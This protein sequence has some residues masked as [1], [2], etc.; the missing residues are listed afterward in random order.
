MKILIYPQDEKEL[1]KESKNIN[2]E[3]LST[4]EFK[5]NITEMTELAKQDGVGLAAAQ[6]GWNINLFLIMVDRN[7]NKI[8]PQIIIN[9]KIINE[10]NKLVKFDEG[11]LSFPELN[12]TISRPDKI[13]WEWY[14][15]NW[16]KHE[17]TEEYTG[18]DMSSLYI[19][20][21]QHELDHNLGKLFI[22]RLTSTGRLKFE[23]WR[24]KRK[25]TNGR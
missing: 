19:R 12:L 10:S 6:V 24:K 23:R 22:D 16:I 2:F 1:R 4:D 11:C 5:R 8:D 18:N 7:L 25:E 21:I 9:P 17:S 14:D 20:I 13:T 15:T 3:Y